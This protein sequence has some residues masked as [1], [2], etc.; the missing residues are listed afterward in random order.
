M[1][2]KVVAERPMAERT[3]KT[4]VSSILLI[5]VCMAAAAHELGAE[6]WPVYVSSPALALF[7]T[8]EWTRIAWVARGL[9]I[10][11]IVS[12]IAF[13]SLEW[14]TPQ[15]LMDAASRG[16]FLAFFLT[17]LNILRDAAQTSRLI[18]RCGK[19]IVNQS[20]GRRYT[21]LTIGSHFFSV[22][23]NFGT[24]N[25]LGTMVRRTIDTGQ[26]GVDD[27]VKETRLER[28]STALLRGFCSVPMWAPTS[29]ATAVVLAGMPEL[30]WIDL[31]PFGVTGAI[32]YMTVGWLIDR[33]SFPRRPTPPQSGDE[34]SVF[35]T[36]LPLL[37]LVFL[38]PGA[39]YGVSQLLSVR[40][41]S[42]LLICIPF[43]GLGWI[44]TQYLR[45]GASHAV[46][47]TGRRF[48]RRMLPSFV[49]IRSEIGIF[50]GSG[51]LG[52]ILIPQIDT[53]ALANA[54]TANG[55]NEGVILVLSS[56]F[57]IVL[58]HLG[59]NPIVTVTIVAETL[60]RLVGL[61]F[62]LPMIGLA[63][64]ASWAI[65]VG[66]SPISASTRILGRCIKKTP[67][68]IGFKWN[69]RFTAVMFVGLS[70]FL[71]TFG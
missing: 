57:I 14:V 55:L 59:L 29:V 9:I 71:F 39:S 66:I 13:W 68:E 30:A 47:L 20:P 34:Q 36:F 50:V 48:R 16:A 28:M 11:T 33:L 61:D 25:L 23:L 35:L 27:Q 26:A 43:F 7:F 4:T 18:Q 54:I 51:F 8:L 46:L 63:G 64:T 37:T 5:I 44:L 42:A 19:V 24:I 32:I 31:V 40:L 15:N 12:T 10:V 53:V 6:T 22:L 56:W 38:I 58:A 52:V 2:S 65:V 45:A 1:H 49:D 21:T 60:P 17:S 67:S 41:I 62:Y 3:A 69:G 70:L